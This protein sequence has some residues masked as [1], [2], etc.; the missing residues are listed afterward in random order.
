ML[1]LNL[2]GRTS[3]AQERKDVLGALAHSRDMSVLVLCWC[4][5]HGKPGTGL[6][7][8]GEI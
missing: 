3:S 1:G 5:P 8:L 7:S 6:T 4:Q 2:C